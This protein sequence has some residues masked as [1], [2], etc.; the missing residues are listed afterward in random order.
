LT[1]LNSVKSV[2]ETIAEIQRITG[3]QT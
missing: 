3:E 1:D 2:F